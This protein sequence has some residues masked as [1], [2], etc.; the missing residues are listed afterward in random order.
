MLIAKGGLIQEHIDFGS[1]L[2]KK[3]PNYYPKHLLFRWIVLRIGF[4]TAFGGDLS[5]SEK[6][7]EIKP[8]LDKWLTFSFFDNVDCSNINSHTIVTRLSILRVV[9]KKKLVGGSIVS[10]MLHTGAS[11]RHFT[12]INYGDCIKIFLSWIPFTLRLGI[13]WGCFNFIC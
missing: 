3:V 1:N 7:S 9:C 12:G 11:S 13:K 2:P 10:V 4:G 8:P 6:L 5:H